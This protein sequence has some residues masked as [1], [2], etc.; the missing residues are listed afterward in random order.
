MDPPLSPLLVAQK[1]AHELL[2]HFLSTKDSSILGEA[3]VAWKAVRNHKL[4]KK[5]SNT[6][7]A[8]LLTEAGQC[9]VE[10]YREFGELSLLD[11]GVASLE[12]A[13][14]LTPQTGAKYADRLNDLAIG[15]SEWHVATGNHSHLDYAIEAWEEACQ[16][17]KEGDENLPRYLTNLCGGLSNRFAYTGNR[18]DLE[19]SIETGRKSISLTDPES[20]LLP[21]RL[22]NLGTALRERYLLLGE[23]LD[24]QESV[25][26]ST[27]AVRLARK[28]DHGFLSYLLNLG[29]VL[30]DQYFMNGDSGVLE[31]SINAYEIVVEETLPASPIHLLASANL[32]EP[33]LARYRLTGD[34]RDIKRAIEL[35]QK[36]IDGTETGA[37]DLLKYYNNLGNALSD[38]FDRTGKIKDL[39]KAID[40]LDQGLAAALDE[41]HPDRPNLLTNLGNFLCDRHEHTGSMHDLTRAI[42]VFE[43]AVGLTHENSPWLPGFLNNLANGQ[44]TFYL[45]VKNRLDLDSAISNWKRAV[46][47]TPPPLPDR[48][49]YL[50]NL[51]AGYS[52]RYDETENPKDLDLSIEVSQEA[53]S[54]SDENTP[55]LANRLTNLAICHRS[56]FGITKAPE[57]LNAALQYGE[58]AVSSSLPSAPDQPIY[59][60][61]LASILKDKHRYTG[62]AADYQRAST[63]FKQACASE[64][65]IDARL[66]AAYK[67]CQWAFELRKWDEVIEA[68]EWVET[69][70]EHLIRIQ[71]LR[72]SKEVWLEE[73][74]GLPDLAAYAFA[75]NG[76]L[77]NAI[78]VF[79]RGRAILLMEALGQ[80]QANL[81]LLQETQPILFSRYE[82][83]T[84]RIG[85]LSRH[86]VDWETA[87]FVTK[88]VS[89]GLAESTSALNQLIEEIRAI[90]GFE[91]FL[92]SATAQ[93]IQQI[94]GQNPLCFIVYTPAGGMILTATPN[95]IEVIWLSRLDA[96]TVMTV[97]SAYQKEYADYSADTR[98]QSLIES[99]ETGLKKMTQ[100]L[101]ECVMQPL[102]ERYSGVEQLILIPSGL[103]SMLPLHAA[104]H[105]DKTAPSGRRFALD[106]CT[107]SYAANA[108]SLK[109]PYLQ[110]V[111]EPSLLIIAPSQASEPALLNK[112]EIAVATMHFPDVKV[113][114]DTKATS[115]KVLE[116]IPNHSV[117]HLAC[118]GYANLDH[119]LRS[120][121]LL[122]NNESINV[123]DILRLRLAE[124]RLAILSACESALAGTTLPDEVVGLP[125]SL[126][127][128]GFSGVIA[129]QWSVYDI[130]TFMVMCSLYRFWR[131]ETAHPNEALRKA[132]LWV[133][134]TTNEEK[135]TYFEH[136]LK[137]APDKQIREAFDILYRSVALLPPQERSYADLHR[138]S[139]FTFIGA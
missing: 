38:E 75:Q 27:G 30:C 41:A 124:A 117:V 96:D 104:W 10:G 4:L 46:E 102:I 94:A 40:T 54:L 133:R 49:M 70:R 114:A 48:A 71:I 42:E 47:L 134:D 29:N 11:Q 118:H 9:F 34:E 92:R 131:E 87:P 60:G 52:E 109:T 128:A 135:T 53:L 129:S 7:Q 14:E 62:D 59:L 25:E 119:P 76:Q 122:A 77:E 65:D 91:G 6:V 139:A 79:E 56:R 74:Q 8:E 32:S 116:A 89:E 132:Q 15:L 63:T 111:V 69:F 120:G 103:L 72:Q 44:H 97:V 110:Q 13:L 86:E 100:W 68:Y 17:S 61:N 19:R 95:N 78:E 99:W 26:M 28:Q 123:R 36:A 106:Y 20:P 50:N 21:D 107:V 24:L 101:W 18:D 37:P 57:D 83:V 93:E 33:L 66:G 137:Q 108:G 3:V 16:R 39:D 45:R 98:D 127:Q 43:E 23:P 64:G 105:N 35:C 2:S 90:E 125:A 51:G 126:I 115:D 84:E 5:A 55:E 12:E 80:Y 121:L 31:R 85:N 136:M 22:D 73:L 82:E 113:L 138:W 81:S 88:K 130:T 58:K 112:P 67:W 1:Q